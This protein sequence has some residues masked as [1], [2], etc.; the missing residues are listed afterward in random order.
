M[1]MWLLGFFFLLL[2]FSHSCLPSKHGKRSS[3]PPAASSLAWLPWLEESHF[4]AGQEI[5]QS[6]QGPV[7]ASGRLTQPRDGVPGCQPHHQSERTAESN[8]NIFGNGAHYPGTQQ[9]GAAVFLE[10][11]AWEFALRN[12]SFLE[13]WWINGT[14]L[15]NLKSSHSPHF[16]AALKWLF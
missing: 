11:A 3:L 16:W 7:G 8:P 9:F 13:C 4:P 1:K 5:P 14:Y 10:H 2:P 6:S 15:F 12:L